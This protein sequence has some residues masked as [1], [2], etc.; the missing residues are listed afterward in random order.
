MDGYLLRSSI[1]ENKSA[2]ESRKQRTNK[3]QR[4]IS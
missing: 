2:M 4:M 3:F 1:G